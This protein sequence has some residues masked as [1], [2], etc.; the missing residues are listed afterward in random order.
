M[1][2]SPLMSWLIFAVSARDKELEV[3]NI[4]VKRAAI[5]FCD[6]RGRMSGANLQE[7][8]WRQVSKKAFIEVVFL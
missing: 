4:M 1:S 7:A 8:N 2:G 5:S 3:Q 6:S